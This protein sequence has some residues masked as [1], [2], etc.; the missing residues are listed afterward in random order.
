[1]KTANV[2]QGWKNHLFPAEKLKEAIN[3]LSN[4]RMEICNE[5]PFISTKHK[6][7]RPDVHCTKCGC[8]LAAKTKV[9]A[10]QCPINNW[11]PEELKQYTDNVTE[12]QTPQDSSS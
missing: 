3:E 2:I 5:C 1:M 8:T 11:M 12:N 7:M 9:F 4:R 6:T 10:E